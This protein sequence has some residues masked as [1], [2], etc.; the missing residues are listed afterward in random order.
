MKPIRTFPYLTLLLI[1]YS[2][3]QKNMNE[4]EAK[5]SAEFPDGVAYEIFIQ[6]WAD[7]NDDGIGDFKGATQKLDYLEELGVSAVWLM[8]IMPS[9]SYHKY[10]VTD[11]KAIHPDYGT[12]EDFKTFLSEAHK[13]NIK[14]V[15]DMI[16]NHTAAE[17]PWFLE[18][19]KGKDNPYRDFYVWA[20]RDSIANQIAKKEV[21]QDSDNITQWHAVDNQKE[22]EH[23]YGFF[24]GGM[25]DLNFDNPKVREEIYDIGRFWLE[26]VGVDGFRLDAA[27]HI[28][29][30]DRLKDSYEFWQEYRDEMRKIKPDVYLVGEVWASS[31]IVKEF[32]KGLPALFNFDLAGSI[33][34][35]VMQGKDVAA[36]IEGPKW[37]NLENEDLV[38][39]LIKQR[40]V[41]KSATDDYKDAIFLSNHDQNRVMS[42]F[43]GDIKKAK[44]AASILF[45]LPGTPYIYYGEEIG[46]LGKKPDPNIRE[47]FLWTNAENDSLRTSWME[48]K[49]TLEKSVHPLSQ[50]IENPN[51]LWNHYYKWIQLRN[52]SEVLTKGE[53]EEFNN[54]NFNLLAFSRVLGDEKVHVIHNLSSNSQSLKIMPKEILFGEENIQNGNLK[55]N[56]SIVF[57]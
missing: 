35:S 13:R 14:V 9:P 29:P 21:S 5:S 11:Y 10:D 19:K 30:D 49:F 28:F 33:Q 40:E 42:N 12:M 52:S 41:F 55:A 46:M 20:D 34:Q 15:I 27:K 36:T 2:C 6:S 38:S 4:P 44:M 16:I 18:A 31:E 24:W 50:Q 8:P 53:I 17:H 54:Q 32:A 45:T 26:D 3:N 22:K 1:L 47:P 7:G 48:P 57:K 37:V 43:K 39:R 25:P 56:S 51:S 23:Y